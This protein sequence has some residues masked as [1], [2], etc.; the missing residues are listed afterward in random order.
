MR[1]GIPYAGHVLA[2]LGR[3]DVRLVFVALP[4]LL[5]ALFSLAGLWHALGERG[6][7]RAAREPR[8]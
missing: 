7:R 1:S 8:S 3:R 2:A 5:I 6:R 4:A